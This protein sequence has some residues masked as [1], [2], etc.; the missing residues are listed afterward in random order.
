MD[1]D[2]IEDMKRPP[3]ILFNPDSYRGDVLQHAGNSGAVTPH[4][5][6]LSR[7][8]VS[9][10]RTFA[11]NPVCTPSR[12]S[13]MTGWYTHVHGHRSMINMLKPHEPNLL[14]V[15]KAEGYHVFW[16]GKN[17]LV[18]VREPDDF[19]HHCDTKSRPEA[20]D[21]PGHRRP[22][23]L[24]TDDPRYR[25]FYRGVAPSDPSGS[26]PN[27][28]RAWVEETVKFIREW[29]GEEPFCL[30]IPLGGPHP[31]YLVAEEYYRRVDPAKLPPRI[32][33][34]K[35]D[36]LPAVLDDLREI[37][38][39]D[40]MSEED[41]RELKHVYYAMCTEIDDLF[42]MV[43]EALREKGLY[44]ES[45]I[46]FFSDHG[47]FAGDYSLPE[48]THLTLQDALLHV[49]F[50]IK[51]P[52][53]IPVEPGTRSHLTELTDLTATVYDL[54]GIDPGYDHFGKSLRDSIAGHPDEHRDAVFA[55]VGSRRG[56]KAFINPDSS[57]FKS[58]DFYGMQSH[59]SVPY[60]QEGSLAVMCRTETHKLV[61][62]PYSDCQEL[63]DLRLDPGETRNLAGLREYESVE[64]E[65][66]QRLLR[67]FLETSDVMPRAQDS[68]KIG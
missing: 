48:K 67:F 16:A 54:L 58:T 12:C 46:A 27:R 8:G 30:Y 29:E 60:H 20:I 15:M 1:L 5:D 63:Y 9:F 25:N 43:V 42:G 49:P 7:D 64:R 22:E 33:V 62:R 65:L 41:W 52:A 31:A 50:L 45:L 66:D 24:S 28:D 26:I 32:P 18:S 51:P 59:V 13:F 10:T 38:R 57:Q 61:R 21:Y 53:E 37:Y 39:A 3:L 36:R 17:D 4:L 34:P 40:G 44:E 68:R 23:S 56:E 47:D 14:R 11:Q 2:R 55:A 19:F 6:A 35:G